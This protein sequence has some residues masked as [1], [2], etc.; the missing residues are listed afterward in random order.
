MSP[1]PE[2]IAGICPCGTGAAYADCCEVFH[3]GAALP[4]SPER[5]MRSRFAAFAKGAVDYLLATSHP[6]LHAPDERGILE[7]AV[8]ETKWLALRILDAPPAVGDEGTVEFAAWFEAKP[9]GQL[10]ERS[11]F[12]R[13][14]GRWFY[15]A[16][17]ILPALEIGRN[18]PCWCGSGLKLKKCH[19]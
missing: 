12:V 10:R 19:G 3:R 11:A 6:A 5:L 16:G 2:R 9:M 4:P 7:R 18:D 14:G 1:S 13:E 17:T 15:R 8:R